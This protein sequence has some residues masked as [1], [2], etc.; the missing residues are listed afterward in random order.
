MCTSLDVP[1]TT[2]DVGVE[3]FDN[4]GTLLN[5]IGV[6]PPAGACN[7]A[8]LNVAAGTTV[9]ISTGGTAQMHED[10]KL[11]IAAFDNGSA[12]IVSTS[13]KIVCTALVIDAR[14]SSSI[15]S[16]VTPRGSARRRSA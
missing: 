15:R 16:P 9:T 5:T 8:I 7:G 11:G 13:S 3:V 12:R 6:T 1:G 10:C 2:I 4:N 14:T